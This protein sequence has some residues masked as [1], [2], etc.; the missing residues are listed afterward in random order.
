LRS[1]PSR[2]ALRSWRALRASARDPLR[3]LWSLRPRTTRSPL[4]ALSTLGAAALRTAASSTLDPLGSLCAGGSLRARPGNSLSPLRSL[5][6]RP[7]GRALNALSARRSLCASALN[8]LSS[9][10]SLRPLWP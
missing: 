10:W 5:R 1:R 7:S 2:R 4:C 9:L 6:S 3:A 8:A